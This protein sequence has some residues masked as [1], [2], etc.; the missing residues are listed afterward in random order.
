MTRPALE[1]EVHR[2]W[3][4]SSFRCQYF[5]IGLGRTG[6]RSVC[7]AARL[8]GF[9]AKH[10]DNGCLRC[11]KDMVGKHLA[12]RC[13]FDIYRTCE[14]IGNISAP[15]WRQ[16]ADTRPDAKF[17]LT[18]RPLEDWLRSCKRRDKGGKRHVGLIRRGRR[19]TYSIYFRLH[20]FGQVRWNLNAW[21]E[22]WCRHI[23]ETQQLG[24]RLLVMNVFTMSDEVLWN[25]LSNFM[26]VEHTDPSEFPVIYRRLKRLPPI[27]ES[28]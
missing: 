11:D 21:K 22:G 10:G 20:F 4:K 26:N 25:K 2:K 6:S 18:V 27:G 9:R 15:F 17:I 24:D 28:R 16:L 8:L 3:V 13:N 7:M 1:C 12:G 23:E 5:E 19:A 14:Y